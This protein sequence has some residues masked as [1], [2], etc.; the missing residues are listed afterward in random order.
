MHYQG[1]RTRTEPIVG[2]S[3]LVVTRG[4]NVIHFWLVTEQMVIVRWSTV[5]QLKT[6]LELFFNCLLIVLELN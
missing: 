2:N 5:A 6:S 3:S 1:K 4:S